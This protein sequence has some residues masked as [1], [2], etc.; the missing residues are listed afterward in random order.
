MK[1]SPIF[2]LT[3]GVALQVDIGHGVKPPGYYVQRSC[4]LFPA[5]LPQDIPDMERVERLYN[6]MGTFLAKCIQDTRLVDLP[7]SR[8]FLKMMCMGEVGSHLSQHYSDWVVAEESSHSDHDMLNEDTDKELIYDPPKSKLP[9]TPAWYAGLLTHEDFELVNPHRARFLDQLKR[10]AAKK[11]AIMSDK[12]LNDEEM[13]NQIQELALDNP[14][15]G[16]SVRLEHL[17]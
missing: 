1:V 6:F 15:G 12:S 17:G 14:A 13:H 2:P 3:A 8:P 11:R 7:L 5:P 10:L 4:G 9:N 16:P